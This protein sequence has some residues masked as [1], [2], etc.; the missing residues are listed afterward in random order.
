LILRDIF[1]DW[2]VDLGILKRGLAYKFFKG[3]EAQQHEA[4]DIIGIQAPSNRSYLCGAQAERARHIEVLWNWLSP[5]KDVGCSIDLRQTH[6]AGRTVLVYAGNMG[7]A[8]GV[9]VFVDLA[10]RLRGRDDIGL[11]FVGRG[12]ELPSLRAKAADQGLT[13]VLFFDE[14]DPEEIPGLLSQCQIGLL[15]LDPRHRTHNIPGKFLAYMQA[16]L[17]VLAR[18]NANNDLVGLIESERV[19][20]VDTVQSGE[21][22]H[23]LAEGMVSDESGRETMSSNGRVLAATLFSPAAAVTQI[24]EALEAS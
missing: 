10:A 5:A 18:I 1:P 2:A 11:L 17:P 24:V 6:L 20:R 9:E 12:S 16:G 19:G 21:A 22:L 4:A 23:E 3:I 14:V 8:Q 15:A 13:N 7:I